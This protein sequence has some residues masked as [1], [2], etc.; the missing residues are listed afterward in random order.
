MSSFPLELIEEIVDYLGDRKDLKACSLVSRAWVPRCRHHLFADRPFTILPRNIRQFAA[1][2]ASPYC[3]FLAHVQEVDARRYYWS[4]KDAYFT[5]IAPLLAQLRVHTL[6]FKL[7]VL[8]TDDNT[9][10]FFHGGFISAFPY[11][12][13]LVLSCTFE[14]TGDS[15]D[16]VPARLVDMIAQLPSLEELVMRSCSNS[17]MAPPAE[18][19]FPPP[20]LS[21][22]ALC[23]YTVTPIL[24]WLNKFHHL[25][26]L[27]TLTLPQL[28]Q[29]DSALIG[30]IIPLLGP[31]LRYLAITVEL[32]ND[33]V[34]AMHAFDLSH[35]TS[36]QTLMLRDESNARYGE[37]ATDNEPLIPFLTRLCA[38]TLEV[39]CLDLDL[40]FYA[41]PEMEHSWDVLDRHFVSSVR[42]PNLQHIAVKRPALEGAAAAHSILD[43]PFEWPVAFFGLYSSDRLREMDKLPK[44]YGQV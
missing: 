30:E 29:D 20:K 10:T 31:T 3:T 25:P 1:F 42:F 7:Q 19:A 5:T 26:C 17:P 41:V 44:H 6:T 2:L 21:S 35:F 11:T 43:A 28:R 32:S 18:K 14:Q 40:A 34:D 33:N 12:T 39:V 8:V 13:R 27:H 22:I 16:A 37:S 15:M 38:P 9:T 4:D 23:H 24:S 36:L